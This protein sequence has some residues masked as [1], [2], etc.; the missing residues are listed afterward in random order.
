MSVAAGTLIYTSSG[1]I[2]A[3]RL[4]RM[5]IPPQ[6]AAFNHLRARFEWCRLLAVR[7]VSVPQLRE[8]RTE[9][10]RSLW[11]TRDHPVFVVGRGYVP[12][13]NV[14]PGCEVLAGVEQAPPLVD[15][16]FKLGGGGSGGG[17]VGESTRPAMPGPNASAG[18]EGVGVPVRRR[19]WVAKNRAL[20]TGRSHT[21]LDFQVES[22]AT[23]LA[24]GVLAH[25]WPT[26]VV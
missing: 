6:I 12:A 14:H 2:P 13:V 3:A 25:N 22:C 20:R 17:G 23:Y 10:A 21:V 26:G 18:G 7:A 15:R 1:L 16:A 24:D 11:C 9:A 5:R 8:L 4:G 19:D